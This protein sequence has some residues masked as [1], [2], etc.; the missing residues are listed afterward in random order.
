MK[1]IHVLADDTV[2]SSQ[3]RTYA[4]Y[5]VFSALTRHAVKFRRA[6]VLLR[7]SEDRGRCD[8]VTCAVTIALDPS[9][10]ARVRATGPHVYAAINREV[11]RLRD[12]LGERSEER[13]SS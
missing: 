12:A 7:P 2:I 10:S 8:R 9:G 1:R 5:R 11:D 4:E 13:R 3:A 6:R